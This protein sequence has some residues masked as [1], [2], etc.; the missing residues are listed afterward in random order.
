MPRRYLRIGRVLHE[1]DDLV[2]LEVVKNEDRQLRVEDGDRYLTL[3]F[4]RQERQG[5]AMTF[6]LPW[7]QR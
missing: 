6:W 2:T 4:L 5:A 1:D 7:E 3:V